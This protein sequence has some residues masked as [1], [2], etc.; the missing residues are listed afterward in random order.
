MLA[1]E[2]PVL[3]PM[4]TPGFASP[5]HH[6]DRS[7]LGP[8]SDIYSVGATLYACLAAQ[9]PPP[10]EERMEKDR[11]VSARRAACS[12]TAVGSPS[13]S[14]NPAW[15]ASDS[16]PASTRSS[17]RATTCAPSRTRVRSSPDTSP[18]EFTTITRRRPSTYEAAT[19]LTAGPVARARS[20]HSR[21]SSA[22]RAAGTDPGNVS[23]CCPGAGTAARRGRGVAAPPRTAVEVLDGYI[24]ADYGQPTA[25]MRAALHACAALEGLYLDPVYSGKAMAGLIDLVRRGR[26]ANDQSVVFL[27][28]GGT[29]ALF[30]Y[31]EALTD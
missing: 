29:P 8:W 12:A 19:W 24:G 3:P 16:V 7:K 15:P 13:K 1:G 5:E 20:S 28:T 17:R 2:A 30:A 14:S 31:V 9:A 11:F 27:H 21:R 18:S 25:G 6:A 23:I 22:L 26:F 10:A 4:Y